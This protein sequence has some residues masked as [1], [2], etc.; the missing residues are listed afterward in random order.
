M[1][2][3]LAGH[4]PNSLVNGEGVRYVLFFNGCDK[5]CV[6]CHN[7]SFQSFN[8][9]LAEEMEVSEVVNMILKEKCM[10]DGVTLSGG[11][12]VCQPDGLI[13]LCKELKKHD[14]NIWMYTGELFKTVEEK[15]PEI[16]EVV[17]VIVDGPYIEHLKDSELKYRGSSNQ[18][19]FMK[20]ENGNF[21]RLTEI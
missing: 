2:I 17:D 18:N 19:I 13:A 5:R 12:P 7:T 15:H 11:D 21:C 6:G 10:V 8:N 1:K 3:K 9:P 16:L 4:I 20:G 14:I